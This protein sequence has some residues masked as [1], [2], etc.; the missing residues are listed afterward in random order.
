MLDGSGKH[1]VFRLA[2]KVAFVTF[3]DAGERFQFRHT[4]GAG[5]RSPF[6]GT[7]DDG[8]VAE[9]S[10]ALNTFPD[11][12][13][14]RVVIEVSSY[15]STQEFNKHVIHMPACMPI[16]HIPKFSI[17]GDPLIVVPKRDLI[18]RQRV[19]ARGDGLALRYLGLAFGDCD[20]RL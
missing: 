8:C 11:E 14:E 3:G 9:A 15:A 20:P 19:A 7:F 6:R 5:E 4:E 13:F 17:E 12:R 16:V 10:V 18:D 1:R 2:G